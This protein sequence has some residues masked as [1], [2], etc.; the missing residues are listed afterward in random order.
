M[1]ILLIGAAMALLM[2][3]CGGGGGSS[4]TTPGPAGD[5]VAPTA[6]IQFPA[7]V[8]LTEGNSILVTGTANDASMMCEN[9]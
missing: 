3:G 6:Q 7:L 1:K 2:Y 5:A 8:A 4:T 9:M